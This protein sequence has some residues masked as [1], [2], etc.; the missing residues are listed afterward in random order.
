MNN[1]FLTPSFSI[2][3]RN[4]MYIPANGLL[5][6]N[7]S[8]FYTKMNPIFNT[9]GKNYDTYK[10][11]DGNYYYKDGN[12]YIKVTGNI[13]N[14][15]KANKNICFTDGTSTKATTKNI[16]PAIETSAARNSGG[17]SGGSGG[18][19]NDRYYQ[20]Q[21]TNLQQ[22]IEELSKPKVWTADE[23][24]ELY[25]VKDQYD[26]DKILKMYNDATD[27]YY[28]D[29]TN[30]QLRTNRDAERSN[31]SY[32]DSLLKTYLSGYNNA[33]PTAV[34]KGTLAANALSTMLGADK[35]NEEASSNLNSIINS[36]KEAWDNEHAQNKTTAR[37]QYNTVGEWL[38]NKGANLN[39][40]DVQNYINTLNA[41]DTEYSGLRNAQNNLASTA[42]ATYQNNANAALSKNQYNAANAM[43][44][45][46]QAYYGNNWTK[47]YRNMLN[48]EATRTAASS[49]A[50]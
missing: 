33:A 19:T 1:Q 5:P 17:Y 45:Y 13:A 48:D 30:E 34:G 36:Y 3:P 11:S 47:A 49:S 8:L 38:L 40:A 27:Q 9:G 10:G 7:N 18:G 6:L 4:N 28:T 12:N 16:T 23:L 50:N 2:P 14:T 22:K 26:Y 46:Y 42:A 20:Q 32:A 21:I 44:K 29:A 31:A 37:K 25:G 24:A 35:A 43:A 15:I 39:S 41:Y